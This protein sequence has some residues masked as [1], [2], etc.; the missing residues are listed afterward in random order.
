M[1]GP[2]PAGFWTSHD[3]PNAGRA[4]QHLVAGQRYRIARPFLDFDGDTHRVGDEWV[5]CGF[6]FLPVESGLSLFVSGD[7][8]QEWHLRLWW[9]DAGQGAVIDHLED[10]V[11]AVDSP[12]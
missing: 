5:F 3:A 1:F 11:C 2:R 6:S 9:D 12:A 7:G 8:E 4:F 10:Y